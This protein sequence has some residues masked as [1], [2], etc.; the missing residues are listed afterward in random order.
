MSVFRYSGLFTIV[1]GAMACATAPEQSTL[2]YEEFKAR[3]YYSSEAHAYIINGDEPAASE[4]EL[5]AAYAAY[6]RTDALASN[7]E[8]TTQQ[9][10]IINQAN[11]RDDR[12]LFN[13]ASNLTYCV[14]QASFGSRYTTVVSAIESAAAAW[15]AAANVEFKHLT[16]DD[17]NCTSS[18]SDVVFNV[19]QVSSQPF[20]ASS[21]F[22]SYARASRELLI[23]ASSF[24]A[25]QP[26]TLAGILRHELGHTLGF[27]HEH[28]RP[29]A[30]VCFEDNN[31]R[32]LTAYDAASV[33]HYP[34]CHGTN[35]GDL[36]LTS[37]DKDG[38]R[39]VYPRYFGDDILW[40]DTDGTVAIWL[41]DSG[42]AYL[43]NPGLDWTIQGTGDFNG[44]GKRDILWRD[45]DGTVAIWFM[46]GGTIVSR[47][48]PA[49]TPGVP[50][51]LDWT[52][53]GVGDFNGDGK[54]DILF[55][56]TDGTVAIW[57]MN[58]G[59]IV[60]QAFP[61]PT[62]GVPLGLDWTIQRAG[63]FNGD[64][65]SDILFRNSDGTVAIWFMNG[66]TIVSQA[67]P[68]P[69]PGVP[70]GLDWAI[71]GAGDFNG[72]GKTD[73]LFRDTDGTVAIWFMNGG[74]IVSQ[75]FPT[76]TPGVPPGLDWTIQGAGDFNG[77]GKTDILFRD[78]DGTVAIWF[79]NGGTILN[80]DFLGAPGL[81]WTINGVGAFD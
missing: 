67:F 37:R 6:L 31:W 10:L 34:Q 11:G 54:S 49:P 39:L 70:P 23:D 58:G 5:Q 36:V 48:F 69:T 80:Q 57:F 65:K 24:G 28:T 7:G 38:A 26:I 35:T 4:A 42:A 41:L 17:T 59:T 18:T 2:S 56:N 74:T 30:G 43:A 52:I 3:A 53:R 12:W 44:D 68:T 79:M 46:N 16:A 63:D 77:D 50:P 71:Q 19:R 45:T 25:I 33:M 81:D 60:S 61:A 14:S 78:T 8:S 29:E 22:P 21:F 72:D 9:S 15:R 66:G 73:I 40:R 32:A 47:A 13:N 62:P 55:R 75:A 27:R 51:G 20:L 76:P 1:L 64:G